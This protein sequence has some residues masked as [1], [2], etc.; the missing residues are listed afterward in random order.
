MLSERKDNLFVSLIS[1]KQSTEVFTRILDEMQ[2]R[3]SG[4]DQTGQKQVLRDG[5]VNQRI[6]TITSPIPD[7]SSQAEKKP[8]GII[9]LG[10]TPSESTIGDQD[11][12]RFRK[13]SLKVDLPSRCFWLELEA[14]YSKDFLKYRV[15]IY[16]EDLRSINLTSESN[17]LEIEADAYATQR[18][19][20]EKSMQN[21]GSI[22]IE[23]SDAN[24]GDIVDWNLKRIKMKLGLA[25]DV[26]NRGL[27]QRIDILDRISVHS[28]LF[29][30]D[31]EIYTRSQDVGLDEPLS[32]PQTAPR[33]FV[34]VSV[35][36]PN[37]S[38]ARRDEN[39]DRPIEEKIFEDTFKPQ[40]L[41]DLGRL[42]ANELSS[43]I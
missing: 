31:N 36:E 4:Q 22:T 1:Q 18:L 32:S 30:L 29:T 35:R 25:W 34:P 42:E 27:A 37:E 21:D 11:L 26:L 10:V 13:V 2:K 3:P 12:G 14:N 41:S 38:A 6:M 33:F 17:A 39:L 24:L 9:T 20:C 5:K 15:Q 43:P 19:L 7:Q 28:R 23:W 8:P 40:D 16:F